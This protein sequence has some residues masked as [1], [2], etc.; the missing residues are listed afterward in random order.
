VKRLGCTAVS[1]T[2]DLASARKIG[3]EIV[4]LHGGRAIWRGGPDQLDK[5]DDP[6]VR[7]FVQGLPDGPLTDA[8]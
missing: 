6:R 3:D 1:I 5:T 7:Q 4:L 8:R 2:H